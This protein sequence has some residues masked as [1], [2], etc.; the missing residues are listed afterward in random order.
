MTARVIIFG[1]DC[2]GQ[3]AQGFGRELLGQGGVPAVPAHPA[4]PLAKPAA[5][6][7]IDLPLAGLG[8]NRTHQRDKR[9]TTGE[10]QWH[11]EGG[12]QEEANCRTCQ[13]GVS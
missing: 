1:V 11:E 12:K 7:G 13:K 10:Y 2:G 5:A 3:G 8:P 6:A 4:A 9:E